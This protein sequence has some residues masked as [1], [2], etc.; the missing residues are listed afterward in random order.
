MPRRGENIYKRK[1]GRWEARYI[2]GYNTCGKAQYAYLYAKTYR[3]AKSKLAAHQSHPQQNVVYREAKQSYDALIRQWLLAKKVQVKE[4]T[5]ARYNNLINCYISPQLGALS[6]ADIKTEQIARFSSDLIESGRIRGS[7]GLSSKMVSDILSVIKSTLRF[8]ESCG[9]STQCKINEISIK[10]QHTEMRVLSASEQT[11]LMQNL[12]SDDDLRKIGVI[13]SLYTGIRLGEVC[14]LRWR[15]IDCDD[16]ILR[17][18]NTLQR[19]QNTDENPKTKTKIVI[20]EAKSLASIRE[21]PIPLPLITELKLYR[22]SSDTFVLSGSE[23]RY[24]EPRS[25]QNYFKRLIKRCNLA[26]A[27]YHALRH[28]FA[29]RCVENGFDTKS[30][31]EILGHTDVHITLN[32]YVHSSFELKKENMRKL[33]SAFIYSPSEL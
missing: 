14:A 26:D 18:R 6:L 22:E 17:I 21:I 19:V 24:I 23:T 2:K 5:F 15:D 3:D 29:T 27:N 30:L 11:Q 20:T 8:A 25:M 13:L 10:R 33:E 28:T 12:A 1:D 16:G 9:Y 7:G 32:R 31:S 4:S